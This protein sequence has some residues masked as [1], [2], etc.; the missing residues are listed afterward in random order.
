MLML[1]SMLNFFRFH[2]F[3]LTPRVALS[4]TVHIE[5][6]FVSMDAVCYYVFEWAVISHRLFTLLHLY[7]TSLVFQFEAGKHKLYLHIMIIHINAL[8]VYGGT[9]KKTM[10]RRKCS[11]HWNGTT[12]DTSFSH[13][14]FLGSLDLW[15]AGMRRYDIQH[16]DLLSHRNGCLNSMDKSGF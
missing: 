11:F 12:D 9:K 10:T 1:V 4:H 8:A 2:S 16:V 3:G 5:F 13:C 14:H 7:L 6:H 15:V